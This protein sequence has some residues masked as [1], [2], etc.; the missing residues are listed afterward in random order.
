VDA[1]QPA[2]QPDGAPA[3]QVVPRSNLL[4]FHW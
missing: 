3:P 2:G 4:R 1:G